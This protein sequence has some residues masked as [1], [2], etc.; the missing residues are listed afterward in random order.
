MHISLIRLI[1]NNTLQ[2]YKKLLELHSR[3]SANFNYEQL[4]MLQ[5]H[6]KY[7]KKPANLTAGRLPLL[8]TS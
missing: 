1:I 6:C 2:I 4:L 8:I 3:R 7:K 5:Y